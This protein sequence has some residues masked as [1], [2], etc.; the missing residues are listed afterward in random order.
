MMNMDV[1]F[2]CCFSL[3]GCTK[4]YAEYDV[5]ATPAEHRFWTGFAKRKPFTEVYIQYLVKETC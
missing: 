1:C 3:R 4:V 2:S 5:V